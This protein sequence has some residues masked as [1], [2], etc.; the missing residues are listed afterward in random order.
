MRL[1]M[2]RRNEMMRPLFYL[3][4]YVCLL[5]TASA[6]DDAVVQEFEAKYHA[7][8]DHYAIN[9]SSE[10]DISNQYFKNIV[11]MG[12]KI[13]PLLADKM[14]REKEADFMWRAIEEIAKVKIEAVYEKNKN[15]V[16]FPDYPGLKPNE[17]VYLRWWKEDRFKT[18]DKFTTLY[19]QWKRTKSE[20][21]NKEAEKIYEKI[22]NLGI[23]VLPYLVKNVDREPKLIPA[24]SK[25]SGN[26]LPTT[27]TVA[28][29]KKWWD[30]NKQKYQLPEP[31]KNSI[32][33]KRNDSGTTSG[34]LEI[35]KYPTQTGKR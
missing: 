7:W 19:D 6:M 21:K 18:G 2:N 5:N 13:L 22:V 25:L 8:K 4:I 12:P 20:N 9:K 15:M 16:I 1:N 14:E 17:N 24:I 23:P 27:A 29:S 30:N 35:G 3:I 26:D 28:I 33:P 32:E 10:G 31:P 11:V 34:S